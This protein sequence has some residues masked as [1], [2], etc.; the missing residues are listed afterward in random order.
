[1]FSLS[2]VKNTLPTS[3][4]KSLYYA[5]I[6]PHFLYC[7]PVVSCTSQQNINLLITKQ[8]KCIRIICKANYNAHTEPLFYDM[9]ILPIPDLILQQRM[10]FMHSI[11]YFYAPNSF[12]TNS[13]FIKNHQVENHLYPL[14]N[15]FIFLDYEIMVLLDFHFILLQHLGIILTLRI[16]RLT[17]KMNSESNWKDFYW[18][19]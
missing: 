5:L 15:I 13:I 14:R 9:K 6:H 16:N 12:S 10:H 3:S 2:K 8:K 17:A 1:M 7:L 11:E 4:L 18:I 19:S